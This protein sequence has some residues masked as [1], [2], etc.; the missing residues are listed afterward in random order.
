MNPPQIAAA[1]GLLATVQRAT[2]EARQRTGNNRIGTRMD[3]GKMQVVTW[4]DHDDG[5]VTVTPLGPYQSTA[6][7]ISALQA[8][9]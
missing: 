3:G 9:R 8:M 5:E 2:L 6:E 7:A 4:I 1:F